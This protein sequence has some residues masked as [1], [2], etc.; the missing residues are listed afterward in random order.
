MDAPHRCAS[1][2][3]SEP[4]ARFGHRAAQGFATLFWQALAERDH[5]VGADARN[6]E[7]AP[8][9][10]CGASRR[11]GRGCAGPRSPELTSV[12]RGAGTAPPAAPPSSPTRTSV[13]R[14][15]GGAWWACLQTR[16][17]ELHFSLCP[18]DERL[19]RPR[20]ADF[21]HTVCPPNRC[22]TQ[23][24]VLQLPSTPSAKVSKSGQ[25]DNDDNDDPKPGRHGDPFVRGVPTLRRAGL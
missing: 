4:A 13:P 25:R 9:S 7:Q 6:L 18:G 5:I 14:P 16:K 15:A 2:G 20:A 3:T 1:Q 10:S 8:G 24:G 21:S 11:G 22:L 12:S 17:H 19:H 23:L